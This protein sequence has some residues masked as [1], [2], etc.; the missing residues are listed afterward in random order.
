MS[1]SVNKH[2]HEYEQQNYDKCKITGYSEGYLD[3]IEGGYYNWCKVCENEEEVAFPSPEKVR[4]SSSKLV[5]NRK[6][7]KPKVKITCA[8]GSV[9]TSYSVKYPNS[10]NPGKYKLKI[11]FTGD[12]EGTIQVPYS[13]VPTK[14]GAPTLKSEKGGFTAKWKQ[15]KGVD[16]YQIQWSSD[17]S[18][19]WSD[20]TKNL[21]KTSFSV[22]K[23]Y[24]KNISAYVHVRSYKVV[25]GKK[26]YSSWSKTKAAK[27]K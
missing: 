2:L 19:Y 21:K 25:N 10:K 17:K 8:D 14:P 11:T 16:G 26:I 4:L 23:Y 6:A 7:Q 27:T 20:G 18:F 15:V 9:F 13:I 12:Y 22:K 3:T 5:Y 24:I 1:T